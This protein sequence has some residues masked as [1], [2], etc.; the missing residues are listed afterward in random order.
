MRLSLFGAVQLAAVLA[1]LTG[2]ALVLP[3]GWA[4]LADGLL[5]LLVSVASE[6]VL[7][8]RRSA[9]SDGRSGPNAA[10]VA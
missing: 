3:L 9:P 6:V 5:V 7:R 8:R 10:G 1:V 4:L 2:V